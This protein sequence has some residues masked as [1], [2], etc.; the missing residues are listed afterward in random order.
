MKSKSTSKAALFEKN[1]LILL[2]FIFSFYVFLKHK[3]YMRLAYLLIAFI[4]YFSSDA[5]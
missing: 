1:S 4:F 5:S 2:S 3:H